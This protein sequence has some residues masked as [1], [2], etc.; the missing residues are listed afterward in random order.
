[1]TSSVTGLPTPAEMQARRPQM[2]P[3]LTD[4]QIARI[5]RLGKERILAAGEMLFD[6]GAYGVPIHVVLE[7]ALE[8]VLPHDG[9]EDLIVVHGPGQFT[10]EVNQLSERRT[11]VR[12]RAK[13]ASRVVE[14]Q[15]AQLRTIVQTDS[16]LSEIFLRA[17]MLRR[18]G[19]LAGH[20]GDAIVLGSSHSAATLR[21]QEFLTR[22]GHPHRYVDVD[23]DPAVQGLFDTFHVGVGDVPVLICRGDRV[24][25][26]PTNAE[27]AECLGLNAGIDRAAV[28]DLVVVGAGPAGLAAAVYAASEGLD[29]LVV[30]ASAPGGQAGSS[31]KIENYLGF[32]TGISGN[33]L[34]QRALAQAEK[35]GAHMVVARIAVKLHCDEHPYRLEMS[36]G[37]SVRARAIVIATGAEYRK[38]ELPNLA[39]F[40]D[41]GVYYGATFVEAQ[42]CSSEAVI[43]VGG[44]NSAGQ[45]ATYLSRSSP[46]VHIVVRA[47]GL[48]ASMSRYLIRRIEETTNITLHARTRVV[49]LAGENH[50]E[51]VTWTNDV[52]GETST[53]PIRHLFSMT[54][55]KPKTDWLDGCLALDDKG[56][57][58]TGPDVSDAAAAPGRPA[59]VRPRLYLE[60][61]LPRIFAVG[62]VR[63]GSV[64][65]VAASVGEGSA[66]IQL[67]HRVLAEG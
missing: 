9:L 61:S 55:A 62:D 26:N 5:A 51:Q 1:M 39:K 36:D 59:T 23:V 48:A 60:T 42:R 38:L 19:L 14:V 13:V 8:I 37:S 66:C 16:E 24:L 52:T 63:S 40:E 25:K 15:V 11:L 44:G 46:H 35:F 7:G 17:Y 22:N 10:G 34:A 32:P 6:Q 56:F 65:R 30:E 41:V 21:L 28:R 57:I 50:V 53:H 49:G 27:V 64:K 33:A 31:S 67:V 4:A 12:G 3:T 47:E 54:G 29:V 2:F 43:V 20:Q 45:A 58:L 18:M